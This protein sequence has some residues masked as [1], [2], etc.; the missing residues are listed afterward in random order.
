M[1]RRNRS[2]FALVGR[3]R[4]A[5]RNFRNCQDGRPPAAA[6]SLPLRADAH[7]HQHVK[8]RRLNFQDAGAHLVDQVEKDFV[9]AKIAQRR[10]EEFWIKSNG[11]LAPFVLHRD[12]FLRFAHFRRIGC[13]VDVVLAEIQLDRILFVARQQRN[14]AQ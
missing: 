10:H 11:K 7:R 8:E 13:D 1:R 9:F 4:W 5:R 14:A 12:G 3:D 2:D 6:G